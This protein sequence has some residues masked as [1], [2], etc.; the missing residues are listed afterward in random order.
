MRLDFYCFIRKIGGHSVRRIIQ[1]ERELSNIFQNFPGKKLSSTSPCTLHVLLK[2][3]VNNHK[4]FIDY[5]GDA[6]LI[7]RLESS[8]RLTI[9]PAPSPGIDLYNMFLFEDTS[10][11][12][13]GQD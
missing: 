13:V 2:E 6:I 11:A 4:A 7:S 8:E 10:H 1:N 12:L 3:W 9:S 5:G